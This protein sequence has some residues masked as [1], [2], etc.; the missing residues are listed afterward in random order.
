MAGCTAAMQAAALARK[1]RWQ[2]Q[3]ERSPAMLLSCCR[4]QQQRGEA[5]MNCCLHSPLP[6]VAATVTVKTLSAGTMDTRARTLPTAGSAASACTDSTW[7]TC[8]GTYFMTATARMKAET[9]VS[10]QAVAHAAVL[11]QSSWIA[12][13]GAGALL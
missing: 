3:E 11:P 12:L 10:R 1:Q 6:A 2:W 13:A 7:R 8:S 9:G 4:E 5:M